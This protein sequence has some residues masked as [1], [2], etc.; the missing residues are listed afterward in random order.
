MKN[1][2][3]LKYLGLIVL[4]VAAACI[5]LINVHNGYLNIKNDKSVRVYNV[6]CKAFGAVTINGYTLDY[7]SSYRLNKNGMGAVTIS[8][9]V[10]RK[11][12]YLGVLGL[13]TLFKYIS[14]EELIHVTSLKSYKQIENEISDEVIA[15]VI[16]KAY[17][18]P[19]STQ[20]IGLVKLGN[21]YRLDYNSYPTTYCY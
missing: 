2:I 19:G 17:Y 11:D 20:I 18:L 1:K 4:A 9:K 8:G 10:F 15:K 16:P 12:E 5:L 13:Q 6:S 7:V 14:N 3:T 21:G